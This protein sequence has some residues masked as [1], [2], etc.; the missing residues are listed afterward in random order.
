VLIIILGGEDM[1]FKAT[2]EDVLKYMDFAYEL[3]LDQSK[4]AYPT[5]TDGIKTKEDFIKSALSVFKKNKGEIL[6]FEHKGK[7]EG[8][9]QY[10]WIPEDKLVGINSFNVDI[11][12]QIALKEFLELMKTSFRGYE[13]YLGFSKSNIE[14]ISFLEQNGYECI[15]E[16]YNNSFFFKDYKPIEEKGIILQITK[17]TFENFE[18]LHKYRDEDMYWNCHKIFESIDKWKIFVYYNNDEPQGA[19][20]FTDFKIMIEIFGIDYVDGIYNE[21]TFKML[22]IKA[23]NEGKS[24]G[25]KHLTFFN[26]EGSQEVLLELGFKYVGQYVCYLVKL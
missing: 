25:A 22:M 8:W 7:I 17:E 4:S 5:Y 23:L 11:E 12:T 18:I 20:Y 14:A 16:D 2:K 26:D 1:L 13:M 3:A 15:E 21:E 19:I 10:Y 6:L 24:I 9:I